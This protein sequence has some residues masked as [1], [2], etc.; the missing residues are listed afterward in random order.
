[1]NVT[2]FIT[3]I[4]GRND[5][6]QPLDAD[7]SNRRT[8]ALEYLT[9]EYEFLWTAREWPFRRA[10]AA[11]TV[12]ALT[13]AASLP[14]DF[15]NIGRRGRVFNTAT[16]APLTWVSESALL[17]LGNATTGFSVGLPR[18]YSIFGYDTDFVRII[19]IENNTDEVI[20]GVAYNK[21]PPTLDEDVTGGLNNLKAIPEEY[22]Q[23]VLIPAVRS[24]AAFHRGD[25]SWEAHDQKRMRGLNAMIKAERQPQDTLGQFP[26]FFGGSMY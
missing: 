3:Q 24:L 5:N 22:H 10:I 21:K 15:Q 11:V 26:S 23:S 25:S 7:Y 14:S 9:E 20:L 13:G 6:S 16:G 17:D 8:R 19:N 1:M 18:F 4:V 2:E 12:P